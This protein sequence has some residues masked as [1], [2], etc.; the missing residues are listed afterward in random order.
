MKPNIINNVQR[1]KIYQYILDYL[2]SE[3]QNMQYKVTELVMDFSKDNTSLQAKIYKMVASELGN[4]GIDQGDL[5][6]RLC[7]TRHDV[8][9]LVVKLS[10][11]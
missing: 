5:I 8:H 4:I 2:A 3:T 10:A 9:D 1:V 7:E 11:V 6:G